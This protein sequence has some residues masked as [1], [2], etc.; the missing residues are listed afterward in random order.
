MG[1]GVFTTVNLWSLALGLESNCKV[2]RVHVVWYMIMAYKAFI[3]P[4]I[5]VLEEVW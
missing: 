1:N 2:K 5:I 3:T 4:L